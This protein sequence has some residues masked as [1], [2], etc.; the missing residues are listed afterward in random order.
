MQMY[1]E[2][3]ALHVLIALLPHHYNKGKI[4]DNDTTGR[5]DPA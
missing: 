5:F 2:V 3:L 1:Q 4:N